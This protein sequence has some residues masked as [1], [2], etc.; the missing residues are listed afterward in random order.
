MPSQCAESKGT[1]MSLSSRNQQ[2][3][4]PGM[5]KGQR[6][7]TAVELLIVLVVFM[8]IAGIAIPSLVGISQNL[9]MTGDA[10]A[11]VA[12][13]YLARMRAASLG[14]KSRLNVNLAAN[15]YQIDVWNKT[16]S[17]YQ[18]DTNTGIFKLSS[19]DTF[20][21][22]TITTPV[23]QQS[24]IAQGYTGESGCGCIYFNS[25]GITTDSA[26]NPTVNSA[27]YISSNRGY[28]AIAVSIAGQ[29]TTYTR[30]G[31]SWLQL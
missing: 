10:R 28:S 25:R 11:I 7:F 18:L 26:G 19:G 31:S 30:S 4:Q 2:Q 16:A 21:Y 22:G 17:A 3:M 6:G 1:A 27:L 20:G 23:G 24:S 5:K 8:V 14:T 29:V 9:R 13:I 12:Q 15:T